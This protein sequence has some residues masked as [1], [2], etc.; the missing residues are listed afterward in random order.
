MPQCP[1]APAVAGVQDT[2]G[3]TQGCLTFTF[4]GSRYQRPGEPHGQRGWGR[5]HQIWAALV[6][7]GKQAL[8]VNHQNAPPL[9]SQLPPASSTEATLC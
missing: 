4:G 9:L 5:V 2:P 7:V 6:G 8:L 1:S 3:C